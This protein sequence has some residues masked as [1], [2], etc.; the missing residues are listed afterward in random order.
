MSSCIFVLHSIHGRPAPYTFQVNGQTALF[1]AVLEGKQ[2][3][4]E[5]LLEAGCDTNI[6]CT[7]KKHDGARFE[8]SALHEACR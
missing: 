1:V 3:I 7:I 2:E 5:S 8:W 6:I 4:V